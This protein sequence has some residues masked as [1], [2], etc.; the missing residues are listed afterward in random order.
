MRRT[1][2]FVI[3]GAALG[4]LIGIVTWVARERNEPSACPYG[5]RWFL[6]LPRPFLRRGTLLELLN[7][8]PGERVLEVGPGIGYYS[9]DV[10]PRL[11]RDG[12]LDA[13]DLQQPMLNELMRRAEARGIDNIVPTH[14]DARLLPFP[15]AT[16]DAAYMVATLGEIPS[17]DLALRELRRVVKPDGRVVIGEGQPDPHMVPLEELRQRAEAVGFRVERHVGGRAGYMALLR[18][19]EK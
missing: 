8:V 2:N 7:L 1:R 9:L 10:A 15:E 4:G 13:V 18:V 5:Q 12:Q 14:D 19:R 11:V 6:D 16:F 3:S 17:R